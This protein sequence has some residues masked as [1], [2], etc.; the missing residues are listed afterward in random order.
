[1]AFDTIR[2]SILQRFIH[3][4]RKTVAGS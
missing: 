1:M 2:A 3:S 4:P